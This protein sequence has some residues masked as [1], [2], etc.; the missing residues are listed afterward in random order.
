MAPEISDEL[1][2]TFELSSLKL[3]AMKGF[4]PDDWREFQKITD[5]FE[6]LRRFETRNYNLEFVA[7]VEQATRKLIDKAGSKNKSFKHRFFGND[8]FD[9]EAIRRQAQIQVRSDF[10]DLLFVIQSNELSE[11]Q[12]L[13]DRVVSRDGLNRSSKREF[14]RATNRRSGMDRG[15]SRTIGPRRER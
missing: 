4:A 2:Q 5:R 6:D 10:D 9:K 7:R 14:A 3:Q 11:K 1:R 12:K 8:Q 13:M 15:Q